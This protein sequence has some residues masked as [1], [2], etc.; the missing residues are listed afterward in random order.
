MF[1]HAR[2]THESQMVP[3]HCVFDPGTSRE[4]EPNERNT[5]PKKDKPVA[6]HRH[7]GSRHTEAHA[8]NSE[9]HAPTTSWASWE[10]RSQSM[11]YEC[12][13]ISPLPNMR[14]RIGMHHCPCPATLP[15]TCSACVYAAQPEHS[16]AQSG[17]T[18]SWGSHI[19]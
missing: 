18:T 5:S 13:S 19:K 6:L 7:D 15:H 11:H 4:Y 3:T 16:P 9:A 14:T 17:A 10:D 8:A 1:L 12:T 2:C